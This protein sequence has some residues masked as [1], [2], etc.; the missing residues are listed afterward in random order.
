MLVAEPD[1]VKVTSE[2]D[3]SKANGERGGTKDITSNVAFKMSHKKWKAFLKK[4]KRKA[5]RQEEA[6]H[7]D[8][9]QRREEEKRLNSPSYLAEMVA[10]ELKEELERRKIEE[11]SKRQ[12]ELWLFH[13]QRSQELLR[14]KKEWEEKERQKKEEIERK[15]K[16]EWEE[17]QKKEK[18]EEEERKKKKEKQ[19]A[20]L[21]QATAHENKEDGSWHN[22]IAPIQYGKER[23]VETCLFF[24]RT[25]A[26]RFAERCS[27]GHPYPEVS[28]TLM[29]P[30]MY[31]HFELQQ[32]LME[33][34]D[35]DIVL[36][37]E[38][39]EIYNNFK[40]FYED[41]LPEFK[42][43]G[44]VVQFKVSSN[45]EP[46][47]R[48]N[49][50]VQYRTEREAQ[51]AFAQFNGRYYGGKIL[52]CQFVDIAE[53]RKAICGLF[54]TKK[55]PKGKN[56]NFLH[57]FHN[58]NNEFWQADRDYD[59]PA[60]NNHPS[61][62]SHHS[63]WQYQRISR[64]RSRSKTS[65][66]RSKKSR[67]R[68][69]LKSKRSHRHSKSSSKSR[70]KRKRKISKSRSRSRSRYS[71][72]RSRSSRD[73]YSRSRSSSYDDN[74]QYLNRKSRSRSRSFDRK[75]NTH[76]RSKS[77]SY[78]RN[79]KRTKQRS[80][81]SSVSPDYKKRKRTKKRHSSNR[82][83]H[84]ARTKSTERSGGEGTNKCKLNLASNKTVAEK[85]SELETTESLNHIDLPIDGLNTSLNGNIG[86]DFNTIVVTRKM[87]IQALHKK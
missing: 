83:H 21:K 63:D 43:F 66:S 82:P 33:E 45:Y 5:K 59:T 40:E 49:V 41:V 62:R 27:R 14:Q 3:E 84:R 30:G 61:Q 58:P 74:E 77:R 10:E 36:E 19:E 47:L 44:R 38:D 13:E 70:S 25:G 12:H 42:K 6:K 28:R 31:N 35:L 29:F 9:E 67:S 60:R 37:Y 64:S 87:E 39:S 50:Y 34:Y 18:E 2:T 11:E 81:S 85:K 78:D 65:R 20:L 7:R 79:I 51:E 46:H 15:I 57:V 72:A 8:E 4:E 52:S 48:G 23:V 71:R 56:C 22:P 1:Y 69:R 76:S 86:S 26:C 54:A 73:R 17:R 16:E 68:S 80:R 24:S 53:W 55:C 75:T 32:G